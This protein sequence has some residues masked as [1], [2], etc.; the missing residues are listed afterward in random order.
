MAPAVRSAYVEGEPALPTS[1]VEHGTG[2]PVTP[3]GEEIS[4]RSQISRTHRS[5]PPRGFALPFPERDDPERPATGKEGAPRRP[6]RRGR[7]IV[8]RWTTP[9]RR[10]NGP[11]EPAGQHDADID[12]RIVTPCPRR[13]PTCTVRGIRLYDA[14]RAGESRVPWG[15]ARRIASRGIPRDPAAGARGSTTRAVRQRLADGCL[16]ARVM[17]EGAG[18]WEGATRTR[19]ASTIRSRSS[20]Q[21]GRAARD[22]SH[23]M[24]RASSSRETHRA[25]GGSRGMSR[26]IYRM[27]YVEHACPW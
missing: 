2:S 14:G 23:Q 10:R 13:R 9:A 5:Y 16:R 18:T 1:Q 17:M 20:N 12:C 15:R 7:C 3:S 11:E 24:P 27:R 19:G 26:E 8:A 4:P 6:G 25:G 21:P 22:I